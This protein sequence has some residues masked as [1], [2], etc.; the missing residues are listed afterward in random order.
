[1]N[2]CIDVPLLENKHVFGSILAIN[3]DH[4]FIIKRGLEIHPLHNSAF[5]NT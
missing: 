5:G 4:L 1:M 3:Y 2:K